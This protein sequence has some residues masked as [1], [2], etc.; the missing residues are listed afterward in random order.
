MTRDAFSSKKCLTVCPLDKS[1]WVGGWGQ[2][3][4][5]RQTPSQRS[6]KNENGVCNCIIL[7]K[8]DTELYL[9]RE[10]IAHF[11][12]LIPPLH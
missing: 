8:D 5:K 11:V 9:W 2:Q 6:P 7:P 12:F 3:G 1:G 4:P 10:K